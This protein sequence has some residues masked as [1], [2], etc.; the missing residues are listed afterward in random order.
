VK[1]LIGEDGGAA[2]EMLWV[3][4]QDTGN[5]TSDRLTALERLLDR[6]FGKPVSPVDL[7]GEGGGAIVIRVDRDE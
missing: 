5:K 2:L 6:G 7:G 4:A 1:Q 3:I